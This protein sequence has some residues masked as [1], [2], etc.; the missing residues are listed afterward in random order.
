M[1]C[2]EVMNREHIKHIKRS[3]RGHVGSHLLG[4]RK[5][6]TGCP[7]MA[8][9]FE[10]RTRQVF[11]RIASIYWSRSFAESRGS[12][13]SF[14]YNVREMSK[15]VINGL[16]LGST[17]QDSLDPASVPFGIPG[18]G[19]FLE[20]STAGNSHLDFSR[21]G[22]PRNHFTINVARLP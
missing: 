4:I 7:F 2:G 9:S 16:L 10:T 3:L 12:L 21:V 14:L 17:P 11:E 6:A 13:G 18:I 5:Y 22:G 1:A 15:F 8:N 20:A 19:S